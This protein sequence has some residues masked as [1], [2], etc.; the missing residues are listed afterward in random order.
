MKR[1][2]SMMTAIALILTVCVPCAFAAED[3]KEM[4]YVLADGN[5]IPYSI[6]VSEHL[7]NR[8]DADT[9]N[10]Y[11][12]LQN[13]ENMGGDESFEN[14]D[15]VLAW[16]ADGDDIRYEGTGTEPLPVGVSVRYTL[17]GQ[18]MTLD[19]LAGQ[20]GHLVIDIEYSACYEKTHTVNGKETAI[21]LPFLMATVMLADDDTFSALEVT[22]G[23]VVNIGSRTLAVCFGLPGLKE[24]LNLDEYKDKLDGDADELD[25]TLNINIDVS[26]D[27]PTSATISADVTAFSFDGTYTLALCP[28]LSASDEDGTVTIE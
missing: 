7:Y 8:N 26:A 12:R 27:I 16:K 22:N 20:S 11:S 1:L 28:S 14:K 10:D 6:T 19:E 23:R 3:K 5:G 2:L 24:A 21:P 18:E 13:I 17:D 25:D 15:G 9:L 4:V